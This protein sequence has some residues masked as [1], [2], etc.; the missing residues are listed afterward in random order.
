MNKSDLKKH[1]H[2]CLR[3]EVMMSNKPFSWVKAI[4]KAIKC[5]SRRYN[6]WWR[7]A[8]YM[9]QK[10]GKYNCKISRSIN[11]KLCLK[12]AVDIGL[13]ACIGEGL[14]I[15]HGFGIVIRNEA[16]IGKNLNIRQ[17]TT[18]GKKA[19]GNS[20]GATHIG[21]SVDIGAGTCIIG[22]VKV[23]NNVTIGAMS[24]INKD[25]PDNCTVFT[26]KANKILIKS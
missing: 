8:S 4:H 2:E 14:K 22:D 19:N 26:E 23:G 15:N 1:L 18:I 24:F 9:Y 20:S 6:F 3:R 7:I 5:P 16:I 13:A 10:G 25:I 17:N 21:C 11:R 12:Y